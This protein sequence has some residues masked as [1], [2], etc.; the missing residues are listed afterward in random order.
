MTEL[1]E[2]L[3]FVVSVTLMK[4]SKRQAGQEMIVYSCYNESNNR[5]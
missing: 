5:K 3:C 2:K 1:E 4:E